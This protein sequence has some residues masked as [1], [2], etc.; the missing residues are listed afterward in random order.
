MNQDPV[1]PLDLTPFCGGEEYRPYLHQPWSRGDFTYASNGH[2]LVR[3]PRR[4]GVAEGG[5]KVPNAERL[6]SAGGDYRGFTPL[7]VT[8]PDDAGREYDPHA[9]TVSMRGAI[10]NAFYIRLLMTLPCLRCAAETKP[11]EPMPFCFEGGLG[12]LMPMLCVGYS[13]IEETKE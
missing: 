11:R 7:R 1:A 5:D 13:N 9:L 8:L 2:V 3:V 12:F 6:F 10:F 4:A